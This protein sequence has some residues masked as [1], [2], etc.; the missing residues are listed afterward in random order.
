MTFLE[1]VTTQLLLFIPVKFVNENSCPG[2]KVGGVL[3][4]VRHEVELKTLVSKIP[5]F[6]EANLDGLEIGDSITL[7]Q[8]N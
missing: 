4:I 7:A 1:S 6:I 2:I 3:N 5:E 8:L